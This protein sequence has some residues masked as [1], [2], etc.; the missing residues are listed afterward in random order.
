MAD[1]L[2][3]Q[4]RSLCMAAVKG[5]D[6]TPELLVRRLIHRLGYRYVLHSQK[7]P[8]K[9]DL[10]FPSRQKV[11]FIHGCF[12][13]MHTCTHGRKA[14]ASNAEYWKCKRTGNRTRDR[15][16]T[17]ALKAEGWDVLVVWECW[18]RD[19]ASLSARVASFLK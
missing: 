9:P 3:P 2:T 12:W 16:N 10:V 5:K 1:D 13:H 7:L 18:T 17:A 14:P 19:L 15:R 4:Q 11:I 8:G 6:T